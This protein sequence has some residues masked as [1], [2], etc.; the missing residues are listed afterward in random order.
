M[1]SQHAALTNGLLIQTGMLGMPAILIM[2]KTASPDSI[3]GTGFRISFHW[4][5]AF[6]GHPGKRKQ[7][8]QHMREQMKRGVGGQRDGEMG[9]G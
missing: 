2:H 7:I 3:F 8:R 1:K 9:V 6:T 5:M 4:K